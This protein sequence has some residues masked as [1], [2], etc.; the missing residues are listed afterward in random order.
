MS[1]EVALELPYGLKTDVYS[2]S[3]VMHEVLSLSKPFVMLKDYEKFSE[4][5]FR[6]G[7]RPNLDETWPTA[8]KILI[9]EMWSSD[10]AKRPS[11]R[12]VA[13]RLGEV[14]RGDDE[15]LYPTKPGGW[16]LFRFP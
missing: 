3:L 11:S 4:E 2:F 1:P 14:L 10:C 5:V 13:N 8:I 7:C 9:Q 12:E 15:S 16:K 6:G